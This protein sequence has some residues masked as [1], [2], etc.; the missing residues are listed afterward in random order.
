MYLY[1]QTITSVDRIRIKCAKDTKL[2]MVYIAGCF[3]YMKLVDMSVYTACVDCR[4]LNLNSGNNNLDLHF[5]SS[6]VAN[7]P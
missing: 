4:K 7:S 2:S 5:L 3:M 1:I 6:D